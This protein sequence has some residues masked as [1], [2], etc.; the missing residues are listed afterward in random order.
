MWTAL[1]HPLFQITVDALG[2]RWRLER[3][4]TVL[5]QGAVQFQAAATTIVHGPTAPT[6]GI[7]TH[8]VEV[9]DS[10]ALR[11]AALDG[12]LLRMLRVLLWYN[13]A[14]ARGVV[15]EGAQGSFTV[16]PSHRVFL[17][18][19]FFRMYLTVPSSAVC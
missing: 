2:A 14:G 1:L 19:Y 12:N 9:R 3:H 15:A 10:Q 16:C 11:A 13:V 17:R 6:H 5:V 18:M 4:A 8:G 7:G